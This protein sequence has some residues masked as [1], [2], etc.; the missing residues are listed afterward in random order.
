MNTHVIDNPPLVMLFDGDCGLCTSTA[1]WLERRVGAD[2][3]RT[4]PLDH[5]TADTRLRDAVRGR[6]LASSLHVVRPDGTVVTGAAAVLA[7]GRLVPRWGIAARLMDHRV[8]HAVLEPAYRLVARNRHRI[9]RALGLPSTCVI[10][11][12]SAA[13]D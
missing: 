5:A 1:R 6:D 11:G 9:G 8:G 3:L 4:L 12:G 13:P 2:R 10:P 7:A